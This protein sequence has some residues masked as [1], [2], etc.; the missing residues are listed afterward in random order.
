MKHHKH[1]NRKIGLAPGTLVYTG[2][3]KDSKGT[4]R[5]IEYN[6]DIYTEKENASAKDIQP[7]NNVNWINIIGIHDLDLINAVSDKFELHPLVREDV[8]STNQRLKIE[9]YPDYIF[10]TLKSI[11]YNDKRI[12]FKQI[13]IVLGKNY[14]ITFLEEETECLEYVKKRI[15][16][17]NGRIRERK[18]DYLLYALIDAI[19]DSY[20]VTLEK[21][22]DDLEALDESIIQEAN[23][24]NF[25]KIRQLK[26][27]LT[28]L[29]KTIWPLRE[30]ANFLDKEEHKFITEQT[31]MF[32]K[33]LYD[34]TIQ[35]IDLTETYRDLVAGSIDTYNS[36]VANR[37]NEVMKILTIIS[38]IFIPITFIAG[39]YGMNFAHMPELAWKWS[40]LGVWIII[41]LIVLFMIRFF[42]KKSWL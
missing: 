15:E 2:T 30:I 13:S 20:F 22:G 34:H 25:Y 12:D 28:F 17:K 35:V 33:D 9:S 26:K 29:R 8:V 38:T 4:I 19:V 16:N 40:Y 23:E 1:A 39:I 3:E 18:E 31:K 24:D 37:M 32:V 11:E 21:I 36:V 27:E 10:T 5:L 42:R 14:I 6:K 7:N 41:V